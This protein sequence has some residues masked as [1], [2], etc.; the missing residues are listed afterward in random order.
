MAF[1]RSKSDERPAAGRTT[2]QGRTDGAYGESLI[3][4]GMI[5]HGDVHAEGMLR[6]EGHVKGSI[7]AGRLTVGL[8]GTVDGDVTSPAGSGEQ[9]VIIEGRVGGAVRAPRV[10][11]GREGEVGGGLCGAQPQTAIHTNT[12]AGRTRAL[13]RMRGALQ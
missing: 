6:V 4:A 10:E 11:V 12:H 3:A 13:Y 7:E 1:G 5:L 2:P 9:A 8:G